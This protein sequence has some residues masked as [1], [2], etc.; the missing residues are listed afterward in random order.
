MIP[1]SNNNTS[2]SNYEHHSTFKHAGTQ[3]AVSGGV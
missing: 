2:N 1:N 3:G